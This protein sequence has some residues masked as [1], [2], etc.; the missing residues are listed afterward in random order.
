MR[1][2]TEFLRRQYIFA[3]K[4]HKIVRGRNFLPS[5]KKNGEDRSFGDWLE[6]LL[7]KHPEVVVFVLVI[8]FAFTA[9]G[10]FLAR[11]DFSDFRQLLND[12]R[13][14][15]VN[16]IGVA[17]VLL[18]V[19][20]I[21]RATSFRNESAEE[22]ARDDLRRER[23][24]RALENGLTEIK[25]LLKTT[26]TA[27]EQTNGLMTSRGMNGDSRNP[28]PGGGGSSLSDQDSVKS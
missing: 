5:K 3:K 8:V 28:K 19:Y 2:L 12:A 1:R 26:L 18:G 21:H 6:D 17:S 11:G 10:P 7:D 13:E 20:A 9:L 16:V 24:Q 23:E 27:V 22:K 14:A 15:L 4:A 25:N